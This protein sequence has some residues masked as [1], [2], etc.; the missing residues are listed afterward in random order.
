[1]KATEHKRLQIVSKQLGGSAVQLCH[2]LFFNG[3]NHHLLFD[4]FSTFPINI[5]SKLK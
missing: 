1:V 4:T 5:T 2:Y 3:E